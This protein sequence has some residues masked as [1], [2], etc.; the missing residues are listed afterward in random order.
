MIE[1]ILPDQ[2][3]AVEAFGD[4]PAAE[5]FP[6]EWAAVARSTESRRQEFATGRACARAALAR[7]GWPAVAVPRGPRGDPLWPEGVVGSITHC[8]GYRAAAVALTKDV[9]SLGI[10]AEPDEAL[11]DRDML[12]LIALEEERAR[13]GELAA[14]LPGTGWDRLLFSAKESVYKA[15]FPLAR[16]WLGFES[17]HV[18]IDPYQGAFAARLLV[19]APPVGG[20]PLTQLHGRWLADQGLL[21]TAVVVPA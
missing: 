5:L 17:A 10:D 14:T 1:R 21:V 4:D 7:L 11:P 20:A 6:Q 19:A 15:W 3:A 18:S 9:L 16:R 8:A 2:V 12:N 13:L